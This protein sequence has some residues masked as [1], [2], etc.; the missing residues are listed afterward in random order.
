MN[1]PFLRLRFNDFRLKFLGE[2]EKKGKRTWKG[3]IRKK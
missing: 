2:E 3:D 1:F